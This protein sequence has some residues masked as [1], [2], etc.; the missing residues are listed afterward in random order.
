M[1]SSNESPK[2][3][4]ARARIAVRW[5]RILALIAGIG[6]IAVV[7]LLAHRVHGLMDLT[8]GMAAEIEILTADNAQLRQ[9]LNSTP[10]TSAEILDQLD[11]FRSQ[12]RESLTSSE[13]A[14]DIASK[15]LHNPPVV[16]YGKDAILWSNERLDSLQKQ[17]DALK[18]PLGMNAE[19][20]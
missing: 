3:P 19:H 15:A 10:S 1:K 18:P 13:N 16:L 20:R 4:S 12:L 5:G 6:L 9:T 17:I 11:V 8:A 7:G 14:L 2:V